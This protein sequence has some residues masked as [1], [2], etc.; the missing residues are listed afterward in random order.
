MTSTQAKCLLAASFL[1]K[2]GAINEATKVPCCRSLRVSWCFLSLFVSRVE[3]RAAD[4]IE[5][6]RVAQRRR[7]RRRDSGA[8]QIDL[9]A[10]RS[11]LF[12]TVV[13]FQAF[14][15]DNDINEL[16]DTLSRL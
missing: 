5:A 12:E 13:F 15:I 14:E 10:H 11:L 8:T 7:V 16:L 3:L 6:A 4:A 1:A 2:A 9:L